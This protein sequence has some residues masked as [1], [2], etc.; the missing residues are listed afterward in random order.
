MIGPGTR[1]TLT[2]RDTQRTRT[3]CNERQQTRS[4]SRGKRFESARRLSLLPI[5]R[6]NTRNEETLGNLPRTS[7]H[8]RYITEAG[9]TLT[10]K[11]LPRIGCRNALETVVL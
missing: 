2:K 6:P 3:G 8:H 9:T 4:W 10:H 11:M 5:D 1:K 7:L